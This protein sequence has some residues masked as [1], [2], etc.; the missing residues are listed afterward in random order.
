MVDK[1]ASDDAFEKNV[2]IEMQRNYERYLFL[3]WGNSRL[4]VFV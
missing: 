3:R 1:Y 2:E 4:N